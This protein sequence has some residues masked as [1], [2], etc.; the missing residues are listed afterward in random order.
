MK[1]DFATA[2]TLGFACGSPQPTAL[3]HFRK[4]P[5]VD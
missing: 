2:I 4:I 1:L 3:A 5:A